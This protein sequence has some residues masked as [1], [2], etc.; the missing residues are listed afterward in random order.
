MAKTVPGSLAARCVTAIP[1][2]SAGPLW[3]NGK[4]REIER[5]VAMFGISLGGIIVI[6]GILL[7]I[8]SSFIIGLIVTLVGLVF[9]GGFAKGKWY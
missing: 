6:I 7:M 2:G 4:V 5:G 1:S 8:F 3:L 9:F